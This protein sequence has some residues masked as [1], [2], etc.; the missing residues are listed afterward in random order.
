M[1]AGHLQSERAST[2][3]VQDW[4]S[5]EGGA[6]RVALD[7]IR[8]L[9]TADIFTS[10]FDRR[11]FGGAID[12][13]RVHT[14]PMQRVFGGAKRIRPFLPLYP[15]YFDH[16]DLTAYELVV[17]GSIAFTHA[18]RTSPNAKHISY[19]YTPMRYAWDLD[20]YLAG[21]SLPIPARVAARVL[22]PALQRWDVSTASRPDVVVGIS[23]TVAD[24][25]KQL[26]GRDAEVI[27]PPVDTMEIQLA[28]GHDGFLL[29]AARMLAY[30]RLDLAIEAANRL[31]KRLIVVGDGPERRRLEDLAGPTVTFLGWIDRKALVDLFARCEAYVVPG[32]EDFGIAPVEAMAAGKPVIGF[33]TG[34]VGE[35]VIDGE[36]GVLFRRQQID[37]VAAAIERLAGLR[38]DP[39]RIRA[40]ALEFDTEVFMANWRSLLRRE[41]VDTSLY[42]A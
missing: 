28:D 9:P 33:H 4:L 5:I 35:T 32:V 21:S 37:A 19:V 38:L 10:F 2:A 24:R 34:G 8:L 14:W 29:V 42:S 6:E 12:P 36:T 39:M 11:I 40:R 20:T 25:I 1:R 13:T 23:K 30:R 26:W 31:K 22:R 7:L 15:W 3:F 17:S 41:G 18:V 27:Y 16:L